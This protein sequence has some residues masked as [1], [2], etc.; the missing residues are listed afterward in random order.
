VGGPSKKYSNVIKQPPTIH[1]GAGET[2]CCGYCAHVW[3]GCVCAVDGGPVRVLW[4]DDYCRKC[5]SGIVADSHVGI[6]RRAYRCGER[7]EAK[8]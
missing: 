5:G 3:N 4:A 1:E 2:K 7:K 6:S 8:Q